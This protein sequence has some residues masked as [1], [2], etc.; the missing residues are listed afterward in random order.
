VA[1]S[2][3][4][5]SLIIQILNAQQAGAPKIAFTNNDPCLM[6]NVTAAINS[7]R[8]QARSVTPGTFTAGRLW[9]LG[10]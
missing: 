8:L 10:K 6:P 2:S 3:A 5:R 1:T 9:V 4:A 7:I